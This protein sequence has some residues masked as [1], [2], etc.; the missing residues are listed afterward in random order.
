MCLRPS[1]LISRG[2]AKHYDREKNVQE[3]EK[4]KNERECLLGRFMPDTKLKSE[5]NFALLSVR[6]SAAAASAA[7]S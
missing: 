2:K 3:N 5:H 4:K 6:N 7:F 1:F